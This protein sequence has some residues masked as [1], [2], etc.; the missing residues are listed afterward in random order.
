MLVAA[1]STY[2]SGVG[3]PNP[4]NLK[5]IAL[6]AERHS[7]STWM[8]KLLQDYFR[9][10]DITVTATLCTWKVCF[11]LGFVRGVATNRQRAGV[12]VCVCAKVFKLDSLVVAAAV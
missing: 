10:L 11:G 2:S 8:L 12:C 3:P 9:E 7:G 5:Y 1:R 4:Q 6:I